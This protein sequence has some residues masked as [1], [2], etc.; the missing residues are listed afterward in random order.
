MWPSAPNPITAIFGS[1][2]EEI[3]GALAVR[4]TIL[5]RVLRG[6]GGES[7]RFCFFRSRSRCRSA[8]LDDRVCLKLA[9]D[10]AFDRGGCRNMSV[11]ASFM[12]GTRCVILAI[13]V[14]R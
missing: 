3:R 10:F 2:E 6:L 7:G 4:S 13:V 14:G 8:E 12:V 11:S 5:G 9:C 1:R